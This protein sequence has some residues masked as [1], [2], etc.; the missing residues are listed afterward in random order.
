M[1]QVK[2]PI[3]DIR[4]G[5]SMDRLLQDVR[6][7][8]RVLGRN[9]GFAAVIIATVALGIGT[10]TAIFSIVDTVVFKPLPFAAADRLVRIQSPVLGTGHGDVASYPD[11]VA[12]RAQSR[13]FEGMAVFRANDF[14]LVSHREAEHLEGAIVSARLFSLL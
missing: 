1:E 2:E 9:P 4:V 11:F 12:W 14:T 5:G 6:Y 10:T 13:S 3:R 8:F 7:A